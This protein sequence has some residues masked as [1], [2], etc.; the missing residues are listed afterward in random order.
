VE[1]ISQE[2]MKQARGE[3]RGLFGAFNSMVEAGN[4]KASRDSSLRKNV[5]QAWVGS[6]LAWRM[7]S[8]IRWAG[9]SMR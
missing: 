5:S 4:V 3:F 9:S 6:P 1:P 7:R 8:T 2:E